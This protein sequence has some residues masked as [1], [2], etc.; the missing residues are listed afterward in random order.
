MSDPVLEPVL[1]YWTMG[2]KLDSVTILVRLTKKDSHTPGGLLPPTK[3][4][5]RL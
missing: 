1:Y 4:S 3:P 5:S 2:S